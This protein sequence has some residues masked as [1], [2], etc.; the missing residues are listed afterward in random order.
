MQI[1]TRLAIA[2]KI[3]PIWTGKGNPLADEAADL[4]ADVS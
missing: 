3:N 1:N 2:R 4:L